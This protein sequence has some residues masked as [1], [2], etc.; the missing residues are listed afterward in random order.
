MFNWLVDGTDHLSVQWFWYRIGGAGGES[1][2]NTISAPGIV[3]PNARTLE[4][5]YA[6]ALLS[7][8]VD[9]LLTGG[10]A[11]SGLSQVNESVLVRNLSGAPLDLHF[12]QYSDF[13]LN[14][15]AAGD[16]VAL[17]TDILGKY[18]EAFQTK[19]GISFSE[20]GVTPGANRGEAALFPVLLNSLT[21]GAPTTLS[22]FAGPAGPGDA[23][24]AFQWDVT[25]PADG[26]FTFSKVKNITAVPEPSAVA[27]ALL[28]VGFVGVLRRSRK[29][30]G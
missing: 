20:T 4:L 25:L 6:N 30:R 18:N 3:T 23:T 9:Y 26:S 10:V 24:W 17:G 28:G 11:G 1:G 2:I 12:F 5:T 22:N 13:D 7:V 27:L 8:R 21:D 29:V 14:G 15:I 16:T 19:G